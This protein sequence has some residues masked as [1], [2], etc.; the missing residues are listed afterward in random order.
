MLCALSIETR[1]PSDLFLVMMTEK[2]EKL[3]LMVMKTA[4]GLTVQDLLTPRGASGDK[5]KKKKKKSDKVVDPGGLDNAFTRLSCVHTRC[6]HSDSFAGL[7]A[8]AV[9]VDEDDFKL[10]YQLFERDARLFRNKQVRVRYGL[11]FRH[12]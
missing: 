5:K 7:T 6:I 3:Q 4:K 10:S 1:S 9:A 11:T 2:E 8:D 12:C